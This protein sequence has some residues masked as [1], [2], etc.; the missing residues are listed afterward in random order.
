MM[1]WC[2]TI[3]EFVGTYEDLKDLRSVC[4]H[5][6]HIIHPAQIRTMK[7]Y[8][9]KLVFK[10]ADQLTR[11]DCSR[12]GISQLPKSTNNLRDCLLYTSPSPRDS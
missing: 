5:F 8:D 11:L 9:E 7:E 2:D 4:S 6:K 3:F 12:Q 10:Y 1:F